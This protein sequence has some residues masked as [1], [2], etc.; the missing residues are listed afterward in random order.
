[1]ADLAK[2]SV[3]NVTFNFTMVLLVAFICAPVREAWE[4]FEV[5]E[6]IVHMD[7]IFVGLGVL[8]F[9]F[10]CQHSGT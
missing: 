7:T 4:T 5:K 2:T 10:V 1:M 3:I 9:A 6:S 8:S